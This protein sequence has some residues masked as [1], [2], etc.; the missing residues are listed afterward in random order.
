LSS[1]SS[2]NGVDPGV[3]QEKMVIG[4]FHPSHHERSIAGQFPSPCARAC[5]CSCA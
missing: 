3:H 4:L 1:S 5:A 2:S